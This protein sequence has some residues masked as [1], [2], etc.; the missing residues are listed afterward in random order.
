MHR[1]GIMERILPEFERAMMMRSERS[2]DPYT[3]GKHTLAAIEHLDEIGQVERSEIS[4]RGLAVVQ[5]DLIGGERAN[6]FFFE[7]QS[8]ASELEAL[9]EIY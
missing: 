3:V 5:R 9:N 2:L 7:R 6:P 8:D 1:L 4:N